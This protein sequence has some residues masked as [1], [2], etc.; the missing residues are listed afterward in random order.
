MAAGADAWAP[1]P[2]MRW[3]FKD[4]LLYAAGEDAINTGAIAFD[5]SGRRLFF[6]QSQ[7]DVSD[8]SGPS[9]RSIVHVWQLGPAPEAT[10][11]AVTGL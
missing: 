6:I 4:S 1:Q 2:Y 7:G 5:P 9:A 8:G 10:A 11:P 3:D